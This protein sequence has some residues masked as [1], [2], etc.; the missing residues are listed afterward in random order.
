[1]YKYYFHIIDNELNAEYDYEGYFDDHE[2]V[3][4]FIQDNEKV[5]NIVTII[6]PYY[7]YVN[8]AD[9]PPCYL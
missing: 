2:E 9:C 3:E 5:G 4:P 1:M 8:K 6:A 7:E